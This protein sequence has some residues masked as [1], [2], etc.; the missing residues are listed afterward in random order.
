MN[1]ERNALRDIRCI[2]LT[3]LV[4]LQTVLERDCRLRLASCS[5]DQKVIRYGHHAVDLLLLDRDLMLGGAG[6][7]ANHELGPVEVLQ[8][9]NDNLVSHRWLHEATQC[10]PSQL[11]ILLTVAENEAQSVESK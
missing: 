1:Y 2:V 6:D 3:L 4:V 10:S 7:F 9:R 8:V 11:K 5:N